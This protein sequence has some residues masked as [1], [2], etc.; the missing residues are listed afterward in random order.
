[1]VSKVTGPRNPPTRNLGRMPRDSRAE[2]TDW[3]RHVFRDPGDGL[4]TALAPRVAAV[5]ED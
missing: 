3:V 5:R 1:M 2:P 4:I